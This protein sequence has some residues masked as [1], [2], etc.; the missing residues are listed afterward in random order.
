MTASGRRSAWHPRIHLLAALA[1]AR[2]VL[3]DAP[4][5]SGKTTLTEQLVAERHLP[6]VRVR[7]PESCSLIGA[8]ASLRRAARRAGFGDLAALIDE[9][10]PDDTLDELVAHLR[11]LGEVGDV[12]GLAIVVDEVQRLEA[13]AAAWWRLLADELPPGPLLVIAGRR[14]PLALTR[15]RPAHVVLL[16]GDDLA[17][18]PDEIA[19]LL[20]GDTD[21]AAVVHQRTQGWSTAVC[22]AIAAADP[23]AAL[24]SPSVIDAMLDDTLADRRAALAPLARLP[25]LGAAVADDVAGEGAFAELVAS[26]LPLTKAGGWWMMPDT[27][28]EVLGAGAAMSD[29]QVRRAARHFDVATA[30]QFLVSSA[31]HDALADEL[32]RREWGELRDLAVEELDAALAAAGSSAL[33]RR[34]EALLQ[35]ARAAE[36]RDA[37]RRA[38]WLERGATRAVGRLAHQ[39]EAERIRDLLRIPDLD[40][41]ETAAQALLERLAPDDVRTRARTLL[42]LGIA[43]A[44]RSTPASLAL[45]DRCL[46]ETRALSATL[47]ERQWESEALNRLAILVNH[48]GGREVLAAEQ[49][50]A[51]LALLPTGSHEWAIGLTY[52]SDILDHLGR[53]TEAEAA[54][55]EAW[56]VGRRRGDAMVAAYGAWAAAIVRCH[57]GDLQGTRRW[58]DEVE[59]YPGAWMETA[60]GM[61]YLA[62]A[63]DMLGSLGDVDGARAYR[64][65]LVARGEDA[66][67]AGLVDVIDSR[68]ESMYGDPARAIESIDRLAG[69]R[70]A[71]TGTSWVRELFRALA[72]HRLGHS[73]DGTQ[74]IAATLAALDLGDAVDLPQRHEPLLVQMLAAVW[75]GGP[76]ASVAARFDVALLG[77][78]AVL[79]GAEIVTPAPGHPATLTKLVA[80]R[81]S[82]TSE[83]A[84]EALWPEVDAVTGRSRLRNL[85]HRLRAQSG[86]LVHRH[87]EVLELA[88]DVVTDAA[89]F[90]L[91]AT[92]ALAAPAHERAGLARL[93]IGAYTGDLLPG[94]LYEDWAAGPRERLRRRYLSLLDIVAADCLARDDL[95]EALRLL[96]LAIATEPLEEG[97]YVGAARALAARGRRTAAR[98][99]VARATAALVELG[100]TPGRELAELGLQV[101][102]DTSH[103]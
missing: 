58:L 6:A 56:E 86:A 50:A 77:R 8:L 97:R 20:D 33:D 81:G 99:Y 23:I 15:R 9:H 26:G 85:L 78:F 57:A 65:R 100:L 13:D 61:E 3:L 37:E 45:A 94:D 48:N 11:Q 5:G 2:V 30:V 28:R 98:D 82:I 70:Y 102:L 14:I 75:P 36:Q 87:E 38:A 4:G 83:Q 19:V 103:R 96:D 72:L 35:A 16:T 1:D 63:C 10:R 88:A 74:Q 84:I 46:H 31:A 25:L 21:T 73:T 44:F 41:A 91:A 32:A 79:R 52:Y 64:A 59:H 29:D 51:S 49:M 69:A 18:S 12:G 60:S 27:I 62:F 90:E 66:V 68:L 93:A 47:G 54:A 24:D 53:S 34:P 7:L 89:R 95:D 101:G 43:H 67:L 22:I 71:T 55:R 92:E 39:F 17:F 76:A 80:L 40:Q 42:S